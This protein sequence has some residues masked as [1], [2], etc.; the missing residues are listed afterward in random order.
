VAGEKIA[1]IGVK[2]SRWITMHGFALNVNTD[3]ARFDRIIPCG[4]GHVGVT[5]M[6]KILG[7]KVPMG[8]VK[9]SASAHFA[10][11]FNLSPR[12]ASTDGTGPAAS[13]NRRIS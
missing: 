2:V 8:E 13:L 1:A 4:I 5:S 11:K 10:R 7:T 9:A 3:L 6:E 12:A